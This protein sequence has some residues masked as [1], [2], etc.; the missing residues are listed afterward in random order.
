MNDKCVTDE[1]KKKIKDPSEA[2]DA[3]VSVS[4]WWQE[5]KSAWETDLQSYIYSP[6]YNSRDLEKTQ[7]HIKT[8]VDTE[9]VVF[10]LHGILLSWPL[11]FMKQA[12]LKMTNIIRSL[13]YKE[14][15]CKIQDK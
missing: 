6:M 15:S 1:I 13:W 5:I 3:I 8:G 14:T 10:L 7:P 9:G 12:Y 4:Q 2:N 11:C